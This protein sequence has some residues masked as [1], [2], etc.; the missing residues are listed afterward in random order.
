MNSLSYPKRGVGSNAHRA[1]ILPGAGRSQPPVAV[2][3]RPE[4]QRM[5]SMPRELERPEARSSEEEKK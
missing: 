4:D 1:S 3:K 5:K 2:K